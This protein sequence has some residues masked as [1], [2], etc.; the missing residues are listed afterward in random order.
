MTKNELLTKKFTIVK[1][2]EVKISNDENQIIGTQAL[3][4]CVAILLYS[5]TKK[6]AIVSHVASNLDEIITKI[7]KL[8][9]EHK[10]HNDIIKYKIIPGYYDNH[11]NIKDILENFF[12]SIPDM[13]IPLDDNDFPN[14]PYQVDM[15]TKSHEFA[16]DAYSGKFV[17]DKVSFGKEYL[18]IKKSK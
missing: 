18:E 1:M 10:M 11:Y 4:T 3:A 7:L 2:N 5:E 16:F 9:V 17:T 14:N 12:S 15:D 8:I 13:F 6:K